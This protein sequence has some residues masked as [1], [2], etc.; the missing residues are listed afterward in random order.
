MQVNIK[1]R[2]RDPRTP[3]FLLHLVR[4]YCQHR[5][6]DNIVAVLL[7]NRGKIRL[8]QEYNIEEAKINKL[9]KKIFL[10]FL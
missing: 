3:H 1:S 2:T 4:E 6:K 7:D 10:L 8:V 5:S 9:G